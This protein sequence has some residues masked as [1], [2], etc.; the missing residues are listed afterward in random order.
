MGYIA[1]ALAAMVLMGV[2]DFLLKKAILAGV[3][4]YA[5][6]FFLYLLM[7]ILF[8]IYCR[9]KKVSLK[10]TASLMKYAAIVGISIFLGTFFAMLAL[11][12]GNA[13]IVVP[14]A[15]MG[16]VVTSLCAFLF[17]REK[18]TLEKGLGI[19]FA[20]VSLILLSQ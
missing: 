12:S 20:V 7:A 4:I 16:F 8:G 19:L 2:M 5:V 13:S 1:L 17:L 15:R 18:I 11:K 14:I 6:S 3:D 9:W 10:I